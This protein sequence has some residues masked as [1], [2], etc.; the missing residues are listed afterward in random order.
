MNLPLRALRIDG[1]NGYIDLRIDTITG[2]PHQKN[3]DGG[4]NVSGRLIIK[5]DY[6]TL[7]DTHYFTTNELD[8][9]LNHLNIAVTLRPGRA[10]LPNYRA[11]LCLDIEIISDDQ[12]KV[13][14]WYNR[15][16]SN[17]KLTFCINTN[18]PQIRGV[19]KDITTLGFV[20]TDNKGQKLIDLLRY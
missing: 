3:A 10:S 13:S 1:S 6:C 15:V 18:L 9:L 11:A 19:M 20:L 12:V 16:D 8:A 14:G 5:N 2:H 4:Y 7:S 17:A